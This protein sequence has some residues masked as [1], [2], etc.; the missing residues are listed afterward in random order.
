MEHTIST[1]WLATPKQGRSHFPL[2]VFGA[3]MNILFIIKVKK[4]VFIKWSYR[5]FNDFKVRVELK[6]LYESKFKHWVFYSLHDHVR[7]LSLSQWCSLLD[8]EGC[9]DLHKPSN[10]IVTCAFLVSILDYKCC[11]IPLECGC[12]INNKSDATKRAYFSLTLL[13]LCWHS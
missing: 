3:H 4:L 9:L 2:K 12:L 1:R 6:Y 10:F 8:V 13:G 5:A 7:V 11:H